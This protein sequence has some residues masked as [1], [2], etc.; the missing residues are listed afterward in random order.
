MSLMPI[1]TFKAKGDMAVRLHA[2]LISIVSP[3]E[4]WQ[5]RASCRVFLNPESRNGSPLHREQG[6]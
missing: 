1:N 6:I 5:A 2:S 4:G 3:I